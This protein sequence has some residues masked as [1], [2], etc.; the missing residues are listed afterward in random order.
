MLSDRSASYTGD[1]I[2]RL[3][4]LLERTLAPV[5]SHSPRLRILLAH[6]ASLDDGASGQ[7]TRRL[8]DELRQHGHLVRLITIGDPRSALSNDH[9]TIAARKG[10]DP[11]GDR[12][13]FD[14]RDQ[15][16]DVLDAEIRD[17]D[18][19]VVHAQHAWLFAHMALEAGVPYVV[20]V[21]PEELEAVARDERFH[22]IAHESAENAGRL[23]VAD[24]FT[25][26]HASELFAAVDPERF[27]VL[28]DDDPAW[29]DRVLQAYHTTLTN[30]FGDQFHA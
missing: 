20:T 9:R 14:Y 17:F 30:R 12:E 3:T 23:I 24:A 4:I 5:S 18:P 11:V 28:G 19:H 10:F 15:L 13:L 27:V 26:Q 16:R 29:L 6:H 1:S 8:F 7:N 25:R 21:W 2:N 22:R